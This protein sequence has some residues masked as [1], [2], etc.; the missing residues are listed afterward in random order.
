MIKLDV[1]VTDKQG[2][3]LKGMNKENFTLLDNGD[4][5]KL[6]SFRSVEGLSGPPDDLNP[7][8]QVI[9]VL[10]AVNLDGLQVKAAERASQD[11]LRQNLGLLR[12][13]VSIYR[14]SRRGLFASDHG[15]LDGKALAAG[16]TEEA[17]LRRLMNLPENALPAARG[18]RY[19]SMS[20]RYSLDA[21]GMIVLEQRRIP[22]H[23][24]LIWIGPG[25]PAAAADCPVIDSFDWITEFSTRMR[26]ARI[27]LY[28]VSQWPGPGGTGSDQDHLAGVKNARNANSSDLSLP[29]LAARS[30]GRL[31]DAGSDLAGSIHQA[32]AEADVY[33]TLTFDPPPAGNVDEYH[34]LKVE[35]KG[36]DDATAR[37]WTGYYDEPSYYDQPDTSTAPATAEQLEQLLAG[38]QGRHDGDLAEELSRR[39]L[40]ER[41]GGSRMPRL[42][43]TMRGEKS[44][45]AL[46]ALAD[47][48][49]FL[50]APASERSPEPVPDVAAQ[51]EMMS[52]TV[53]YLATTI[54]RLPDFFATR[55]TSSYEPPAQKEKKN[56]KTAVGDGTLRFS[57]SSVETIRYRNGTE[58]V[59]QVST[60][61]KD[62]SEYEESLET[63]G[64][65]GPIL[66]TVIKDAAASSISW[67][68]WEERSGDK[69][70]VFHFVVP[71]DRSH[72]SVSF[73]CLTDMQGS[74]V[75]SWVTGY[76][77]ELTIDPETGAIMR[78]TVQADLEPRLPL[79]RA[80]IMVGYQAV[81]IGGQS[82]I[83]PTHSVALSRKRT[84]TEINEWGETLRTYSP[85]ITIL[86]DVTFTNYHKFG[87]ESRVLPGFATVPDDK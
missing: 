16:I 32:A 79:L 85:F 52:R 74:R 66:Y 41:L 76:H 71:R 10:D 63:E 42:S 43:A 18:C 12:H 46:V 59:D 40:T 13:P 22:G 3:P 87:S 56:W 26:E 68:H 58:V 60:R 49:A 2:K 1:V 14:L 4:A 28:G 75:L 38:A 70:A 84:V 67:S 48:S 51:R 37:T 17:T 8:A 69:R 23:K 36:Q 34:E 29:A 5:Q 7:L 82:Y 24:V 47:A 27:A 11:F 25:W 62:R 86:N 78:L 6:A 20:N 33:Y 39:V 73:C 21:L 65:F 53:S 77:G 54:I 57:S 31:L 61:H 83:C 44:R 55:T 19:T 80:D 35:A 15:S 9:L 64:T 50:L 30:G 81:E 72:Y 45:Q